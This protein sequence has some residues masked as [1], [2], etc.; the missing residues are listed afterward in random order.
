[1]DTSVADHV[2]QRVADDQV[3]SILDR[4]NAIR[5]SLG[6]GTPDEHVERFVDAVRE[7]VTKGAEWTYHT[8]NGRCVP[9]V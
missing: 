3:L 4:L 5:V 6:A 9:A 1:M 2:R 7:L 8:E